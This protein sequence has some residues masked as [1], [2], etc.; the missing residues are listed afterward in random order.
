MQ[1]LPVTDAQKETVRIRILEGDSVVLEEEQ[2]VKKVVRDHLVQILFT[3]P[4][5]VN[6]GQVLSIEGPLVP[7]K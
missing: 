1:P 4:V 3:K 5:I 7:F 6:S 2:E